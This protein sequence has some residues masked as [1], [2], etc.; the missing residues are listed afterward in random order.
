MSMFDVRYSGIVPTWL[1]TMTDGFGIRRVQYWRKCCCYLA[2]GC[3]ISIMQ[4]RKS[5]ALPVLT[6]A[7]EAE[8]KLTS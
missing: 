7:R 5:S 2:R 3:R 6:E 4:W 1:I 8:E